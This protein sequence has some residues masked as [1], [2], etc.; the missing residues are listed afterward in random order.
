M[1]SRVR[2]S[3]PRGDEDEV[4]DC[5]LNEGIERWRMNRNRKQYEVSMRNMSGAA[6]SQHCVVSAITHQ[7]KGEERKQSKIPA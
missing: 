2:P 3:A 6:P 1:L 4:N 5:T 7:K